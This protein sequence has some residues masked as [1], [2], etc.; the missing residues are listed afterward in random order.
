MRKARGLRVPLGHLRAGSFWCNIACYDYRE[1][2]VSQQRSFAAP[3][4]LLDALFVA[5]SETADRLPAI[6]TRTC[7][8]RWRVPSGSCS[9]PPPPLCTF[10]QIASSHEPDVLAAH[11][12]RPFTHI[13]FRAAWRSVEALRLDRPVQSW[14]PMRKLL[15]AR[16]AD[17]LTCDKRF[18]LPVPTRLSRYTDAA[19]ADPSCFRTN[20][21]TPP[22]L[23][24]A[25]RSASSDMDSAATGRPLRTSVSA[26]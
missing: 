4:L 14:D 3:D 24:A 26:L 22:V 12:W 7:G 17:R 5:K 23:R 19:R 10:A 25:T 20:P 8:C 13:C 2:P 21:T 1:G 18:S 15:L 16:R 9:P 11:N 6:A